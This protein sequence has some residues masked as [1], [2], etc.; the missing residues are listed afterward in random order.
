MPRARKVRDSEDDIQPLEYPGA[1]EWNKPPESLLECM[2]LLFGTKGIG[3]SSAMADFPDSLTLMFE[4]KRRG[5]SI[6]QLLLQK[7]SAKEIRD[8]APDVYKQVKATTQRWIDDESIHRLNFDTVDIFYE[9][10]AHSVCASHNVNTPSDAGRSSSDIWNEI[11]DEFA[12]YFDALKETE[13]GINLCSHVKTREVETLEGGKM[14]FAAPSCTPACLKYLQQ[15]VDIC[16][17]YGWY[18]GHRAMM[19]RDDTNASFVSPGIKGKFYQPNGKKLN[20]FQIPD[21]DEDEDASIY[22]A[23][24]DAFNNKLW[25]MDTPDDQRTS[26]SK[27]PKRRRP[28]KK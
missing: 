15:S 22:Q 6:R 4:P 27:K 13:L 14:G 21:L 5:L 26:T 25:D 2:I 3:K 8:G 10:C 1:D 7:H 16:L 19:V 9:S 28:V 20:I 23:V 11:R 24:T 17:F 12:S 18:N